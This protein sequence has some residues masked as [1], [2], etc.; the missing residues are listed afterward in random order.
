[1][2]L[3]PK[4]LT[5]TVQVPFMRKRI[6][7]DIQSWD[8]RQFQDLGKQR[9]RQTSSGSS[10][11]HPKINLG[12]LAIFSSNVIAFAKIKKGGG[13]TVEEREDFLGLV[14]NP[15]RSWL[16]LRFLLC[17]VFALTWV[18]SDGKCVRHGDGNTKLHKKAPVN[19]ELHSTLSQ[20]TPSCY[21]FLIIRIHKFLVFSPTNLY[22]LFPRWSTIT[23]R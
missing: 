9:I 13:G 4:L 11:S 8:I 3:P 12:L 1:M 23:N 19:F 16:F 7:D 17:K 2:Y 21:P 6:P 20:L 5:M 10:Q 14:K 15:V 22:V 18:R